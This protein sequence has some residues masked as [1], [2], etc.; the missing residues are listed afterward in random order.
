MTRGIPH[1]KTF[2]WA[3]SS[4]IALASVVGCAG[5]SA[6]L[7]PEPS[8][9]E[10]VPSEPTA[11][12]TVSPNYRHIIIP[13]EG[14]VFLSSSFYPPESSPAPGILLLHME[15]G[16][17][18][19]WA[20]F[21]TY[22]REIGYAPMTLDLRGH[23]ESSGEIDWSSMPADVLMAW[24]ALTA[25]SEVDPTTSMVVGAGAGADLALIA[26]AAEP[27]VFALILISPS[28]NEFGLQT[29]EA[30]ITYGERPVLIIASDDD[31]YSAEAAMT[32]SELAQGSLALSFY[33]E[34][35]RGTDMLTQQ[36]DLTSLILGWV[37]SQ[38][39]SETPN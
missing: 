10:R 3:L 33:S 36:P 5:G 17:Q 8:G 29:E 28:I 6:S 11:T 30:M 20:G 1:Y 15:N 13:I 18:E 25:Q 4:L 16:R 2:L 35:G 23:G 31:P 32:L 27:N 38:L 37:R 12:P 21:A 22:L 39:G 14:E 26:A 7:S 19:D 24:N 34:A 9:G